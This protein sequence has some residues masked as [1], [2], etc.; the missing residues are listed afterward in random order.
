VIQRGSTLHPGVFE[1][2]CATAERESIPHTVQAYARSTGTDADAV[3]L[4]RAGIPTAGI[5]IALRY[6]HSPV[7]MAQL[8]DVNAAARLVAAFAQSLDVVTRLRRDAAV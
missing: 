2:L 6:M 3:H 7:E 1:R 5:E 4:S 8:S